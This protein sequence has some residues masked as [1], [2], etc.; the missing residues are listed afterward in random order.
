M[1][2]NNLMRTTI[3]LILLASC[4]YQA[5]PPMPAPQPETREQLEQQGLREVAPGVWERR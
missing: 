5:K 4:A 2:K 1:G 3:L